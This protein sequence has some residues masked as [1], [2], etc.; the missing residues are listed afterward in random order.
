V[1]GRV[2]ADAGL[3]APRVRGAALPLWRRPRWWFLAGTALTPFVP[4]T[5]CLDVVKDVDT[6]CTVC[7]R[8]G[9]TVAEVC[10]PRLR[11]P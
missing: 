1:T 10:R 11:K 2:R 3:Q 7:V 6:I 4:T 9:V 8:D 5:W